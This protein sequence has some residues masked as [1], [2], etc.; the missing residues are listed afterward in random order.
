MSSANQKP[1]KTSEKIDDRE[2][3]KRYIILIG[4]A[5]FSFVI[6]MTITTGT[7]VGRGGSKT[8]A[9][10]PN[11]YFLLA[12]SVVCLLFLIN[13]FGKTF[14]KFTRTHALA[15]MLVLIGLI[16]ILTFDQ[17][18][19]YSTEE[20]WETASIEDVNN[21][22]MEA[23]LQGNKNGS[24]L[25]WAAVG[26]NDPRILTALVDRGADIH[27]VDAIYGGTA[28]SAAASDTDNPAIIDVLI[29]HG[30]K[31][32]KVIS[33]YKKSPLLIA[34]EFNHNPEIIKRLLAHG[35]DATHRDKQ[36][37]NALDIARLHNNTAAIPLLQHH[38]SAL[39]NE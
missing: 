28:L 4:I 37:R 21:V 30:A 14:N 25:T 18:A 11:F 34:A 15:G 2:P 8:Y 5:C 22:P 12:S 10:D 29:E 36:K 9:S 39:N 35:A 6:Y 38:Y 26:T 3:P 16:A 1:K 27:E 33:D 23:L 24:V 19:V 20:Y 31:V 17:N 32:N 7:F 13:A